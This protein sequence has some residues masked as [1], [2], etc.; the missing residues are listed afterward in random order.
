MRVH[1]DIIDFFGNVFFSAIDRAYQELADDYLRAGSNLIEEIMAGKVGSTQFE[2][3]M[4]EVFWRQNRGVFDDEF[5]LLSKG[6]YKYYTLLKTHAYTRPF[7]SD[8]REWL[9]MFCMYTEEWVF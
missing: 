4:C 5:K 9:W 7:A 1:G 2:R 8:F 6:V 3:E